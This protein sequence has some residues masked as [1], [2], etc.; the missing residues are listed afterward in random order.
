MEHPDDPRAIAFGILLD[1]RSAAVVHRA[2]NK[3]EF[4]TTDA[5][6]CTQIR[7]RRSSK[8]ELRAGRHQMEYLP[9]NDRCFV[10]FF[11]FYFELLLVLSVFI[12]V[13]PW[14]QSDARAGIAAAGLY[15]DIAAAAK[16]TF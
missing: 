10:S 1:S 12:R 7:K 6:R 2:A 8:L 14:F 16:R 13:N 4:G 5:H 3:R 15:G 11:L 9:P